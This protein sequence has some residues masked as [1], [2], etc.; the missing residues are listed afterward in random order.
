MAEQE[1]DGLGHKWLPIIGIPHPLGSR[2][3]GDVEEIA[4]ALWL[5]LLDT[6]KKGQILA[7]THTA[8]DDEIGEHLE[9]ADDLESIFDK[10]YK[11]GW[12]DGLP[13]VPPTL[14]RVESII[15][16][17]GKEPHRVLGTMPPQGGLVT[18]EKMAVN[19][20]M[21][22]CL[23]EYFPIIETAVFAML[24]EVFNLYGVQTTTHPCGPLLIVNGPIAKELDINSGTNCFGPGRRA[25]AAIGRAVRLILNNIGGA[26]PGKMDMA[27]MGQPGKYTACIAENENEN[28]WEPL[29]V[30]R[31]FERNANTVTVVAAEAP[32]NI[33]D[34]GSISSEELIKSVVGSMSATGCNN[35]HHDNV[36]VTVIF[37][38]EHAATVARGYN[39]KRQIK[40]ILHEMA[41][42]SPQKYPYNNF[43]HIKRMRGLSFGYED[44][45]ARM[46]ISS[47]PKE[48]NIIVAGGPG[49]HTM[50]VPTFGSTHS[51]IRQIEK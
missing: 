26:T 48:I 38:P 46:M 51:V 20:V 24:E 18:I 39:S 27:T 2:N 1:A 7:S 41:W 4:E 16:Y 30:E 13:I 31:G 9:I 22:G 29:H 37:S 8:E 35:Y 28:P 15:K 14:E 32:R 11:L 10:F 19:A 43:L 6:V 3:K 47:S 12:T 17:V 42:V 33:N 36:D 49:K 50:W 44:K 45:S 21:A 23:P 5:D 40:E 25:N 34:H